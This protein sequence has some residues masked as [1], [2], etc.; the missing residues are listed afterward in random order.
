MSIHSHIFVPNERQKQ[1]QLKAL[2]QKLSQFDYRARKELGRALKIVKGLAQQRASKL[3]KNTKK[4]GPDRDAAVGALTATK[5]MPLSAVV[6]QL[7]V[8]ELGIDPAI[9]LAQDQDDTSVPSSQSGAAKPPSAVNERYTKEGERRKIR[10]VLLDPLTTQQR[11]MASKWVKDTRVIKVLEAL[12]QKHRQ[13]KTKVRH[14]RD[15]L[16]RRER[17]EAIKLD[18]SL[19]PKKKPKPDSLL[20][21][22]DLF[23][24][25]MDGNGD[26]GL[27][28][29][30]MG[31]YQQQNG[32]KKKKKNRMGQRERKRLA[33]QLEAQQKRGPNRSERRAHSRIPA[34]TQSSHKHSGLKPSETGL[35]GIKRKSANK[36]SQHDSDSK[37]PR[38][39][40][41]AGGVAHTAG[42]HPSWAARSQA[43]E[44][45][46]NA[47]FS[48]TKKTFADSDSDGE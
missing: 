17:R 31:Y 36:N 25:A 7:L 21:Q 19:K 24:Q 8:I 34:R 9:V 2:Q 3:L 30:A 13:L 45:E 37:R 29:D 35:A 44:K 27:L 43:K 28:T 40:E 16:S 11:R 12:R 41:V 15:R 33:M 23:L 5:T 32:K 39:D 38:V 48:G 26:G 46:K 22:K 47:S 10:D 20:S 14:L 18:P 6:N 42:S 1:K 4:D